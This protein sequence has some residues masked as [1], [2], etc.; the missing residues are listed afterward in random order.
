[1]DRLSAVVIVLALGAC[2]GK[3]AQEPPASRVNAAKVSPKKAASAE[4]FC[5]VYKPGETGPAFTVPALVGGDLPAKT[6]GWRWVNVWASWCKP[7]VDEMPRLVQWH[8]K[9]AAAGKP[10]DLA[11]VSV[12]AD[13]A[14]VAA[15]REKHPGA[16]ASPRLA[17]PDEQQAW[18]AAL[19]LDGAPPIPIH[20]FVTP[21]GHVRCARAGGVRAQDYAAIEAVLTP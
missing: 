14:S 1:M 7:C 18:F 3:T 8:D 21:G 2:D 16:P 15:F 17:N 11:F 5:D 20:V 19:G 10:F 12:D 9:L 6:A 4:E 13:D